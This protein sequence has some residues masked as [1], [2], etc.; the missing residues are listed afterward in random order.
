LPDEVKDHIAIHEAGHAFMAIRLGMSID[1]V[2][3]GE[4]EVLTR[5]VSDGGVTMSAVQR[6]PALRYDRR[7]KRYT[8]EAAERDYA[9]RHAMIS[10]AGYLAECVWTGRFMKH[11][12]VIDKRAIE[13]VLRPFYPGDAE[14]EDAS[15]RLRRRVLRVFEGSARAHAVVPAIA[16]A[17]R[18]RKRLSGDEVRAIVSRAGRR[19]RG[20]RAGAPPA[21]ATQAAAR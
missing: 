18:E 19:S 13:E 16:D 4:R 12:D 1:E 5:G 10:S 2:S 14:F 6:R 8:R 21:K 17:L 9:E 3:I 20:P 15:E 7:R 11:G